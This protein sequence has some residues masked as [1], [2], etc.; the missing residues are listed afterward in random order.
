MYIVLNNNIHSIN[1]N[2]DKLKNN[3]IVINTVIY[4][5]FRCYLLL[6]IQDDIVK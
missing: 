2:K 5:F 1:K 6:K 3:K 4:C